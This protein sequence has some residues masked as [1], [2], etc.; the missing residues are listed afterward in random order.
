MRGVIGLCHR[1]FRIVN[2][3]CKANFIHLSQTTQ[4]RNAPKC[5][6][7]SVTLEQSFRD[8]RM[9][10]PRSRN[11]HSTLSHRCLQPSKTA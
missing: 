9:I 4:L 1:G 11:N 3:I 6:D 5:Y 7:Y 2:Y 10:V 8:H